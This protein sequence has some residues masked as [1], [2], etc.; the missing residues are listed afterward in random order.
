MEKVSDPGNLVHIEM[1]LGLNQ[2]RKIF[3]RNL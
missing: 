3:H 1:F 2:F